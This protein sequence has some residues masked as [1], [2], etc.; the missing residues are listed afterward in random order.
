MDAV[1]V[2]EGDGPVHGTSKHIGLILASFDASLLD[3]ACVWIVGKKPSEHSTTRIV[4]NRY[5]RHIDP[6]NIERFVKDFEDLQRTSLV[7]P[8]NTMKISGRLFQ[9]LPKNTLYFHPKINSKACTLCKT[10]ISNCP[11]KALNVSNGKIVLLSHECLE[12]FCCREVCE[13]G[14]IKIQGH[15]M[16]SESIFNTANYFKKLIRKVSTIIRHYTTHL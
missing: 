8:Q 9:Y 7:L 1:N 5:E 10:C 2:M 15:L 16:G 4:L 6:D 12:C 11:A 14:A 13:A 3:A